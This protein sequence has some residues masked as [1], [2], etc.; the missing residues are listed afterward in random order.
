M[1]GIPAKLLIEE[2]IRLIKEIVKGIAELHTT[3]V[4]STVSMRVQFVK[5]NS[6]VEEKE[7][8]LQF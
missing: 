6:K 5:M 1:N 4:F 2:K 8:T 7:K 3:G